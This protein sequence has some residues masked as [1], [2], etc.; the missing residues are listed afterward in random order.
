[1]FKNAVFGEK[2][3]IYLFAEEVA[4]FAAPAPRDFTTFL[5]GSLI[6]SPVVELRPLR[7][8]RDVNIANSRSAISERTAASRFE[9]PSLL[10]VSRTEGNG[11]V[12][13]AGRTIGF[14]MARRL[15]YRVGSPGPRR[16]GG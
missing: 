5:A 14:I 11:V 12:I 7:D 1:M 6:A 8:L 4:F 2:R 3:V 13:F 9:T 10:A 16:P 15:W